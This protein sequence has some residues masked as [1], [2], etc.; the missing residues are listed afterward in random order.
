MQVFNSSWCFF[1]QKVVVVV[2]MV[3][4]SLAA[5]VPRLTHGMSALVSSRLL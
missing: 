3:L 2:L 1:V 4:A 5:S